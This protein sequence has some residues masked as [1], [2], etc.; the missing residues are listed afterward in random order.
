MTY[1]RVGVYRLYDTKPSRYYI[2]FTGVGAPIRP[3]LWSLIEKISRYWASVAGV[4]D[5]R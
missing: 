2:G 4:K 1:M 3:G 5:P